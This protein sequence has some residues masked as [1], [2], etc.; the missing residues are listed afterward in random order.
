MVSGM[1]EV[2]DSQPFTWIDD[3]MDVGGSAWEPA[4]FQ[5]VEGLKASK[6][7]T[8]LE[9]DLVGKCLPNM[10]EP[11]VSSW[12]LLPR[13]Q[14]RKREEGVHSSGLQDNL[15]DALLS[16]RYSS[17]SWRHGQQSACFVHEL[18]GLIPS[19]E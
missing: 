1:A 15:R 7:A 11:W 4:W 5:Q 13:K 8:G 3:I 9:Y 2:Q 19:A 6:K 14:E 12:H 16:L 18:L 17:R 10:E